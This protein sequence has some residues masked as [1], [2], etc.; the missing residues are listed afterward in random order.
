MLK[1]MLSVSVLILATIISVQIF[2]AP[3]PAAV[4]ELKPFASFS[5]TYEDSSSGSLDFVDDIWI[6]NESKLVRVQL[7]SVDTATSK[8]L[9]E[10]IAIVHDKKNVACTYSTKDVLAI[11]NPSLDKTSGK[12]KYWWGGDR[13]RGNYHQ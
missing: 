12:Y 8:E 13:I 1:K 9:N 10:I 2:A 4:P 3:P 7:L 5:Y 6:N 11:E